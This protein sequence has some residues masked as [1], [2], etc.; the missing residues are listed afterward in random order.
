MEYRTTRTFELSCIW[1]HGESESVIICQSQI[2]LHI[3]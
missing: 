3:E 1:K 2:I